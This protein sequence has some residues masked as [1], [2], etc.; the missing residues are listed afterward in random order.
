M[1]KKEERAVNDLGDLETLVKVTN[2]QLRVR[3]YWTW[4]KFEEKLR[5]M[6]ELYEVLTQ[7]KY[8]TFKCMNFYSTVLYGLSC[9]LLRR[10]RVRTKRMTSRFTTRAIYG[11]EKTIWLS[12][13]LAFHLNCKTE[14]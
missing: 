13:R 12:S 11:S 7:K 8:G 2:K 3:T 1:F 9:V 4:Q 10:A 14:N 5:E 6:K